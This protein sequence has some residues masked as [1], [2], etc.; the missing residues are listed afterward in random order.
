LFTRFGPLQELAPDIPVSA[1]DWSPDTL[2]DAADTLL[3]DP[4]LARLQVESC[5]TAGTKYTWAAT[6]EG[7]VDLYRHVMALTPT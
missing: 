2:A 3:S 5:L 1:E 7:L 4:A 6:A